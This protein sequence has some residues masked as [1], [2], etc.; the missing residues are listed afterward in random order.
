LP[1]RDTADLALIEEAAR[2]GGE[3]A[4]RYF[5]G[6]Y[7]RWD[8][9][10]GQLVTEADLAVDAHLREVLMGAQPSYGWMSEESADTPDRLAATRTFIVDP[11]DGTVAFLKGRP[12][13]TISIAVVEDG[14]P[15]AA[16]VLNPI[17]QENF[18]AALGQGAALNGKPIQ[19]TDYDAIENCRMLGPKSMFEHAIW[20]KAPNLPWPPM[21]IEQRG[22]IAYRLALVGGGDFDATVSLSAKHDWDIAAGDLIVHEAGGRVTDHCGEVLRYNGSS[23][24]Q[25]SLVAAGA[26]L[27][28]LL[29]ERVRRLDLSEN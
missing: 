10:K 8:K 1:A 21:A 23:P 17:T 26:K 12:H 3:I 28:F 9:G 4:R 7:R 2:G 14:R 22:S 16:A 11:I 29:I 5:G 24:I 19:T 13:F 6:E 25:K 18:T 27:H 15:V 20:N